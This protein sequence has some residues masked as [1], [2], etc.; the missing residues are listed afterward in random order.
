MKIAFIGV[1]RMGTPMARNLIAGGHELILCDVK[2]EALFPFSRDGYLTTTMVPNALSGADLAILS[3]PGPKEVDIVMKGPNGIIDNAAPELIIVDT[4]T[5]GSTQSKNIADLSKTKGIH[6]L[7]APITGGY[8][9]AVAASLTIMVGGERTIFEKA[10]QVLS[11]I[12]KNISYLGASG[13]GSGMKLIVQLVYLS[14]LVSFFEGLALG[15]RLG[16]E[17]DDVLNII[18]SSAARHPTIEKRYEKIKANDISPRFEISL[19]LK[20]LC[21]ARDLLSEL[22]G[23]PSVSEGAIQ[24]LQKAIEHGYGNNDAVALRNMHK[25][26]SDGSPNTEN[27][28]AN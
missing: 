28:D 17:L 18:K 6:Y 12:G 5:I 9:G 20:D 8:E 14:Q 22:G 7:D 24:S 27:K 3:L 16:L 4:S 1:G 10:S 19:A 23:M 2:K 25:R 15:D 21:L 11:C 13:S 26:F